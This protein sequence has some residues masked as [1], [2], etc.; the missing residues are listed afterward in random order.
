M[1]RVGFGASEQAITAVIRALNA[2]TTAGTNLAEAAFSARRAFPAPPEQ[3]LRRE[4]MPTRHLGHHGARDQR[5]FENAGL[6]V[7]RPPPPATSTVDHLNAALR[8]LRLKRK[9]QIQTRIV[10][11][12]ARLWSRNGRDW[13][14]EFVAIAAAMRLPF[15]VLDGEAVAPSTCYELRRA[16][17]CPE[18][19][20][21]GNCQTPLPCPSESCP[22]ALAHTP[23]APMLTSTRPR[24]PTRP[25]AVK[26]PRSPAW[27]I[28]PFRMNSSISRST[29]DPWLTL[30]DTDQ[31]PS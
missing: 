2:S 29:Q 12:R 6:V 16:T 31:S 18:H 17:H 14:A 7:R 13:S 5:L 23:S 27:L 1:V 19:P 10:S 22:S 20:R 21:S 28:S 30:S 15:A 11:L 24:S 9:A 25:S 26:K 3:L 4:A 8:P